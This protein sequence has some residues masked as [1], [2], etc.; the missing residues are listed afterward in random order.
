MTYKA[1]ES[2]TGL[3][4]DTRRFGCSVRNKICREIFVMVDRSMYLLAGDL[5]STVVKVLSYKSE[6]CWFVPSC[7]HWNF[8]L[9]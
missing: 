7:C 4:T 6:G 8:S 5:G 3:G 2:Y 1:V 9:K